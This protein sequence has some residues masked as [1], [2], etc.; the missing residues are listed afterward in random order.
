MAV[1]VKVMM[2]V[3]GPCASLGVQVNKPLQGSM[4]APAGALLR[5]KT[6]TNVVGKSKSVAELVRVSVVSSLTVKSIGTGIAK[7]AVTESDAEAELSLR[8]SSLVVVDTLALLVSAPAEATV[9]IIV[10][11]TCAPLG[12][13]PRSN[14]TMPLASA[15]V[16]CVVVA[17][18][19][20]SPGEQ[21]L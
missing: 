5:K 8:L 7:F 10:R 21:I 12:I 15:I 4:T 9:A 2:F 18:T 14:V 13:G 20:I 11:V 6:A 1:S 19:N 17:S 3:L 16:P